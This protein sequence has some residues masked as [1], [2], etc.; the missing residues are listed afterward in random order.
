LPSNGKIKTVKF[1]TIKI[2]FI[3]F[4]LAAAIS[5]LTQTLSGTVN[6]FVAF[7]I[8]FIIIMIGVVFDVIGIAFA[9]CDKKPFVAMASKKI[10]KAREALMLLKN[11]AAV[12]NF[13]NDVVGDICGIV[14]GATGA[15]IAVKIIAN[16]PQFPEIVLG[17]L[18][19]ATVAALTVALKAI[20]KNVALK[21][22]KQIVSSISSFLSFFTKDKKNGG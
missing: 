13:C 10:K 2:F 14:S 7:L 15:A 4:L 8:L 21:N 22:N 18:F 1:W 12:A 17:I 6:L 9:T 19:S 11:A 3:T 5:L 16:N 20:G